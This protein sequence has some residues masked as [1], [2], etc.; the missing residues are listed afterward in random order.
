MAA[1]I[2][3]KPRDPTDLSPQ[4]PPE[5]V[6][7]SPEGVIHLNAVPQCFISFLFR[8]KKQGW[9]GAGAYYFHIF[10]M[11]L[12]TCVLEGKMIKYK[13]MPLNSAI[14]LLWAI[15]FLAAA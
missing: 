1:V 11:H 13:K 6:S 9:N 2:S 8:G 3:L 15:D 12:L 10:R 4:S 7:D 14:S 5:G